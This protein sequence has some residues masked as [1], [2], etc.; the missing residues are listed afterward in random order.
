MP[1]KKENG[2]YQITN[3]VVELFHKYKLEHELHKEDD[4]T[5]DLEDGGKNITG[6][7][8]KQ[9]KKLDNAYLDLITQYSS[10]KFQI[11][12]DISL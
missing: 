6:E 11:E 9:Y 8:N 10:G 3:E 4:I 5:F 1:L 12:E 7:F 2:Q